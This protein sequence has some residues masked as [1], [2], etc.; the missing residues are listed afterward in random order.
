MD[1]FGGGDGGET[2]KSD[3]GAALEF[4]DEAELAA[5]GADVAVQG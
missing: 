4:G 5:E 3:R 2:G 1:R